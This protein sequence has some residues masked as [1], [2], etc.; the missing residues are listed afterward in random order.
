MMTTTERKRAHSPHQ[1][2]GRWIRIDKRLAIYLRDNFTCQLC[3]ED[4]HGASPF[5]ITL[6][7]FKPKA[8]GG[9]ND[10]DNVFTCCRSCNS[11]RQTS[12]LPHHARKQVKRALSTDLSVFRS[13][14]KSLLGDRDD[15]SLGM[16]RAKRTTKRA[17]LVC[18]DS[19]DFTTNVIGLSACPRC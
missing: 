9:S 15:Y 18:C 8:K 13:L 5:D 6:D 16:K 19:C 4:L 12:C 11:S 17:K 10:E 3:G 7:H 14:A 1:P 2:V